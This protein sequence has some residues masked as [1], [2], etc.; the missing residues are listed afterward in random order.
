MKPHR[1][2]SETQLREEKEK[3]RVAK[4]ELVQVCCSRKASIQ[5]LLINFQPDPFAISNCTC[6][7]CIGDFI[8]PRTA[9]VL[10]WA[11]HML[12]G[13]LRMR[14]QDISQANT[15]APLVQNPESPTLLFMRPALFYAMRASSRPRKAYIAAMDRVLV[16]LGPGKRQLPNK[17][18]ICAL[19]GDPCAISPKAYFQVWEGELAAILVP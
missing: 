5:Q 1:Y 7:G 15:E 12:S 9:I 2:Y 11:A 6:N 3:I 16:C 4:A 18:N 13:L 10:E 17:E 14:E 8:S 19:S